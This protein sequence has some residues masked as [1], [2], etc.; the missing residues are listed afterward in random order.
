MASCSSGPAGT[1]AARP[2]ALAPPAGGTARIGRGRA[3]PL[4]LGTVAQATPRSSFAVAI[5]RSLC[6][7]F[8]YFPFY[9]TDDSKMMIYIHDNH[10]HSQ[11]VIRY[12]G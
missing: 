2:A 4:G 10:N 6:K 7:G 3:R 1:A 9:N 11:D 8:G 5:V 12:N